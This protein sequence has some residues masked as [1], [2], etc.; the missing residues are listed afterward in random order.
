MKAIDTD[1]VIIGAGIAGLTAAWRL[2]E[3]GRSVAVLEANSRVGGRIY[4]FSIGDRVVQLGGRW[5]GPGQDAIKRLAGELDV[6]VKPLQ[7]FDAAAE[8]RGVNKPDVIEA[9]R[10]IDNAAAMVPLDQPW[11]VPDADILD[12][13]TLATW[14]STTFGPQHA[15]TLG[16]ILTGFLPEPQDVSLLHA[17][18]YLKSNGGFASILG[19]DGPAHDSEIFVGGAHAMTDTLA[20]RLSDAIYLE[21]SA[22]SVRHDGS[23]VAVIADGLTVDASHAIVTLPPVLAGRLRWDPPLPPA[24]DYLTQRMPIRGKVTAVAIYDQPFWRDAGM[25]SFASDAMIAWDEGGDE[26][27]AAFTMLVSIRRSLEIWAMP[28]SERQAA[29]LDDLAAGLGPDARNAHAV[30]MVNWAAEPWSRGCNSFMTTGAW[31]NWGH[32]L[33]EPVGR[34]RWACAEVSEQFA[35]QMEGAVRTAESAASAVDEALA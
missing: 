34:I 12:G 17:L 21:T 31:T 2:L 22:M 23:G 13:Q 28:E 3:A 20:E 16:D 14:L 33:R 19:L 30:H 24:R 9:V 26:L 32:A 6:A 35:G 7:I 18:F 15:A 29:L 4:G 1:V 25:T 10:E 5:I 8:A 27:P 11:T